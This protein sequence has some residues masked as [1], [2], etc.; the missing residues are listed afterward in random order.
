MNLHVF[1][2]INFFFFFLSVI[3]HDQLVNCSRY[4]FN[5]RVLLSG[6]FVMCLREMRNRHEKL[7]ISLTSPSPKFLALNVNCSS[8]IFDSLYHYHIHI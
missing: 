5:M 1:C 7:Q 8:K 2:T 4:F 3:L 6:A